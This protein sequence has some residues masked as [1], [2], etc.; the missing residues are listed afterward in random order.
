MQETWQGEE[1]QAAATK[2]VPF[3][4]KVPNL[5]RGLWDRAGVCKSLLQDE[6][7]FSWKVW[8]SGQQIPRAYVLCEW[9]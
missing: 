1:R 7:A 9:V 4:L 2:Q 6:Q 5:L 3:V 8:T